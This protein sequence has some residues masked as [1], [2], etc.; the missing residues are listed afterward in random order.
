[1]QYRDLTENLFNR[2]FDPDETSVV[3]VSYK[4]DPDRNIAIRCAK[5][6]QDT[7]LG[8]WIDEEHVEA[9]GPDIKIAL[10]IEQGLDDASALLGIIGPQTFKSPWVPYEIGGA[11]GRQ[12]FAR[13][14]YTP[15]DGPHPLI[16]HLIHDVEIQEVPAFVGLGIPLVYGK[17]GDDPLSEVRKWAKSVKE[18]LQGRVMSSYRVDSIQSRHGVDAIYRKNIQG[19]KPTSIY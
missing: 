4:R 9:K 1:M 11:R 6:L 13:P 3:F 18:I 19:L 5:I 16:A 8:Y 17:Y 14:F 10:S 2:S 7:P 12:R 15:P